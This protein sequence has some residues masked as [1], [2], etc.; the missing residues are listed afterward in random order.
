MSMKPTPLLAVPLL[1]A[2][3]L[4][5]GCAGLPLGDSAASAYRELDG[6]DIA[7][8]AQAMQASLEE[9]P[10]GAS[11]RWDNPDT[12]HRGNITPKATFVSD[13]GHFCRDY[14]EALIFADG[15][16][17]TVNNTACRDADGHWV[18]LAN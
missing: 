6:T 16:Q 10:D 7:L 8:A 17:V 18:W 3:P 12:G 1:L 9:R 4:L 11:G 2:G 15:R 13:T 14:E 5:A